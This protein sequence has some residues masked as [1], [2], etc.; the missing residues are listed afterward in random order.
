M[1]AYGAVASLRHVYFD[2]QEIIERI[3][4]KLIHPVRKIWLMK[5]SRNNG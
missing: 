3:D 2:A 4:T 1:T 5:C